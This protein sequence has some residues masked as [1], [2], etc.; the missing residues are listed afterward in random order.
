MA[1]AQCLLLGHS[2]TPDLVSPE[3]P[4]TS[5]LD[6]NRRCSQ[7]PVPRV[8]RVG[9]GVPS[10]PPIGVIRCS[11]RSCGSPSPTTFSTTSSPRCPHLGTSWTTWSSRGG[12]I[13][14]ELQDIVRER[15]GTARQTWVALKDQ[16]LG[17]REAR[18]LHLDASFRL[19]EGNLSVSEYWRRMKDMADSLRD[20]GEPIADRTLVLNLLRGLSPCYDDLKALIKQ[21]VPFP[22]S[23]LSAMSFSR[24]SP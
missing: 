24:S 13:S 21:I 12:T 23:T 17:N 19:G 10:L 16:F 3:P 22:P 2:A 4:H 20:L 11:S 7:H 15:E 5:R 8:R 18:T 14:V 9:S 6:T 1:T